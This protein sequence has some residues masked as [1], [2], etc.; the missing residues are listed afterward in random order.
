MDSAQLVFNNEGGNVTAAGYLIDSIML[1]QGQ[2]AAVMAGGSSLLDALKLG[3]LAVPL[4]LFYLQDLA[5]KSSD[6]FNTSVFKLYDDDVAGN[7]SVDVD[8]DSSVELVEDSLYEK[9][10]EMVVGG[11][12]KSSIVSKKAKMTRKRKSLGGSAKKTRARRH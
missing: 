4:G 11:G 7:S 8:G 3:D 5:K 10:M 6:S 9:L 2:P 12:D 1:Q